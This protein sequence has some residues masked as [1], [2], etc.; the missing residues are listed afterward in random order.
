MQEV[1][2]SQDSGGVGVGCKANQAQTAWGILNII[3][4]N[5]DKDGSLSQG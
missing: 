2:L 5:E 4:E 3:R 1:R